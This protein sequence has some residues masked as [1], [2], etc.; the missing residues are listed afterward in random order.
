[1]LKR[2]DYLQIEN[3]IV[4]ITDKNRT[5]I[6]RGALGTN[7]TSH[8][9]NVAALKIKVI[10]VETRRNS[11]IRASGHTFEYVGF[12]P[13]NYSTAMP[14]VQ[15][16]VLDNDEQILAQSEQT[17]GG[18]VVYTA[19][20]DKGEFFI[21]RKKI[22]ALTGEEVSTIDEFDTTSVSAPTAQLPTTAS[23]DNLTINQ[24]FYS[25]ANTDLIDV[26]FR[27]NRTGSIGKQVFVGIQETEPPSSQTGD[28][29]LFATSVNRGGYIGWVQTNETGT[30]KWQRFGLVSV[31]NGKEHYAVDNV[32]IGVTICDTGEDLTV[33]GNSS[34]GSLKVDDLTQGRIVTIGA[35]GELQDS[36][37]L[38]FAGSTLTSH[39][40]NVD[41][42]ASVGVDATVGRHLSV[43]GIT[44][45]EHFHSTDDII[46]DDKIQ[47]GGDVQGVNLIAT[48][49]VQATG[50]VTAGTATI[51][52]TVQA[53]QL[54]STDDANI[55][56]TCT[57]GDFVG[58]GTIP[59]GGIIMWSGTNAAVPSNWNLCDGTNG[60]PNLIDK[61]VVGRGSAYAADT[62]GGS[63]DAIVPTHTHTATGGSHGHPVRHSTQTSGAVLADA[64]GGY[65]LDSTGVQD[66]AA[67]NS[68]PGS[69]SGDQIGQSGSLSLTA[70][71][72]A[73]S[74][75]VTNANLPP[76]YAIA[77][78][79][80]IS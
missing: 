61:F 62:T 47:A 52:G 29:I 18:L 3:E 74:S 16:R 36:S 73:G 44:T 22:D 46:A 68:T 70:A 79:M 28:N 57:A 14:Q 32:A 12:G 60:T 59:I 76:Y 6:I 75:S 78:I 20:N 23:F 25:N 41:N 17:R 53:E 43:T 40:L 71:A 10:P 21:G 35:S 5:K 55:S 37:A 80:R 38:T 67:N 63:A 8:L 45:A 66:F 56:G 34:V 65:I 77:Y 26:K 31:E 51:S 1:M 49:N 39:T 11:L 42:N 13:G 58:N 69:T 64:A 4:R 72:P 2:G 7:A 24:N 54:T 48:A 19:M 50:T 30:E 15:D 27:G 9:K 33:A